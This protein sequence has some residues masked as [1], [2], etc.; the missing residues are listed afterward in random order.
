MVR[1]PVLW[2]LINHLLENNNDRE[3]LNNDI[4]LLASGIKRVKLSENEYIEKL[5]NGFGYQGDLVP[6]TAP[7]TERKSLPITDERITIKLQNPKAKVHRNFSPSASKSVQT[8]T[9]KRKY[10]GTAMEILNEGSQTGFLTYTTTQTQ[11]QDTK[12]IVDL[13]FLQGEISVKKNSNL[14][15]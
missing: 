5:L 2:P 4:A 9:Q 3:K 12:K 10:E 7:Q 11:S 15:S 14:L 8:N 1:R 13:S 6:S